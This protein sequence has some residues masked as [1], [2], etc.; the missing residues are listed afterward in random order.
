MVNR[1]ELLLGSLAGVLCAKPRMGVSRISAISD[2]IANTP[3]EAIAFA[4]QY[5]LQWLELRT[6]PGQKSNYFYMD[7]EPLREHARAFADNG[8]RISFLNTSLLKYDIS[9]QTKLDR[10]MDELV[11]CVRSAKILG[12][13]N[14]RVFTFKRVAEPLALMPR[15]AEILTPMVKYAEQE[16]VKLLVEN[17]NSCNVGKCEESAAIL[18]MI[19]SKAFGTNWDAMN[20]AALKE[21]PFPDGY[22][23]LPKDR[24]WNVQIKG[25]TL[26]EAKDRLDWAAI[27]AALDRDG[28]QGQ[29]GLE[30]HYGRDALNIQKSHESMKEILRVVGAIG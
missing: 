19:P 28:Y 21:T 4:K 10:R 8:I 13:E 18:K 1:R 17:E 25:K 14:V 9:D 15:I 2:E 16:G 26:L 3:E 11:K 7:A 30:T 22:A 29:V 20:G 6:V 27:L 5:G 12:C 24:V 23:L